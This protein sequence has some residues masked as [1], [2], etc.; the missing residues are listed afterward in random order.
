MLAHRLAALSTLGASTISVSTSQKTVGFFER[1]GF[2]TIDVIADGY[3]VG[4][5]LCKM[6][7][8]I[9]APLPGELNGSRNLAGA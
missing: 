4:L 9:I 7:M 2:V 1:F 3:G 6:R 5:D 8:M